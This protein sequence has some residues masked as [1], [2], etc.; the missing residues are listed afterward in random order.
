MK[1][2]GK[3]ITGVL[4]ISVIYMYIKNTKK[5]T[6]EKET[7]DICIQTEPIYMEDELLAQEKL[8]SDTEKKNSEIEDN[9]DIVKEN[10]EDIQNEESSTQENFEDIQNEESQIQDDYI[11]NEESQI[12]EISSC[13]SSQE[14]G[15]KDM[16]VIELKEFA[17]LQQI[18]GYSRMK[19][20][21]LVQILS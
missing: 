8:D 17:R 19:K 13:L 4:I 1:T 2:M 14:N 18:K 10:F 12:Q 6:K 5:E 20:A 7:K 15:L 11:Q 9:Y 21:E 3:I 16:S